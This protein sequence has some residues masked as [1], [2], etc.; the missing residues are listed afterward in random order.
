LYTHDL[1]NTAINFK[2][3]ILSLI[4]SSFILLLSTLLTAK[5][6]LKALNLIATGGLFCNLLFNI[7]FIPSYGA[8]G[9]AAGTLISQSIIV[10]VY[11]ILVTKKFNIVL[12]WKS[13]SKYVFFTLFAGGILF[14]SY[15]FESG[16]K[17]MIFL[18]FSLI[19]VGFMIQL[20]PLKLFF[21]SIVKA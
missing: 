3:L 19:S 21:H 12:N 4:P 9:A 10:V 7:V 14:L 15:Y 16:L 8:Q 6:D 17:E 18:I 5:G 1:S 2:L 13:I 11:S 20:I